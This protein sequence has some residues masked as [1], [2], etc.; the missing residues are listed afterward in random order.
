MFNLKRI[1]DLRVSLLPALLVAFLAG[2][3]GSG[4]DPILGT[5][6]AAAIPTVTATTPVASSPVVTDVALNS[7]V[8]AAFSKD[9]APGSLT[10]TSFML[11]CPAGT[12]VRAAISYNAAT[13]V[14]T[15]TP[16]ASL[17][18]ATLCVATITTAVQD[19]LGLALA[20]NVV[21]SFLTAPAPDLT[22]PTVVMT[23][24]AAGAAGVL[25]NTPVT[26]V[27]S[28]DMRETS[29]NAGSFTL[30]NNSLGTVVPG[31]V[32]YSATGR[33]AVFTPAV[34]G[35]LAP[36]SSFTATIT[37][38]AADLAGNTL[39]TNF[40]WT[41]TTAALPDT[42]RP[43]IVLTV[44][45]AGATAVANNTAITAT[46]SED[47]NPASLSATSFTLVNTTLGT[48]VAGTVSYAA[49]GRTVVFTPSTP[50]NLAAN[51]AYTATITTAAT[52]LAGNALASNFVWS[53]TTAATPDTTR[54][55]VITAVPAPN[56]TAV[57]T[58]TAISVSFSE[59]MLANSLSGSSFTVVNTSS[60]A[61]V[62][63]TVS[64]SATAR[65]AVFTPT[66]PSTLAANTRY[67]ATI[68]NAAA[69]LAGNT[70]AANF[71]WSFTTAALADTTRP[72]VIATVPA[73]NATGVA[74]N[75]A[76]SASFSEDM[77]P[78]TLART[79]FTVVDTTLG[80]P[81]LGTVSYASTG[82]SAIFTPS[83]PATL[84]ANTSYRA[85]ITTDATDLA[86]NALAA[87]FVWTFTTAAAA[88]T[89]APSV[90]A[91]V[92]AHNATAVA[93]NTAVSATFDEAMNPA[94]L[95]STSFTLVN[96]TL[97]TPVA[98]TVSY[99][100]TGRTAVFTPSTPATLPANT[101]FTATITTA[102]TDLAGNAL[103]ASFVWSFTTAA[104]A[105]TTRPTVVTT[106][107]PNN[108]SNV[109]TNTQVSASF[110]ED[111]NP[112]SI[113]STSFRLVNSGTGTAV[114]G[115]VSYSVGARSATFTPANGA[116]LASNSSYTAR[117]TTVVTD[118]AGN[119]LGGNTAI[120][121]NAGDHVW[122]FSTAAAGDTQP[123]VI[124][125]V[126]PPDGS[127]GVCLGTAVSVTFS[128]PMDPSTVNGNTVVVTDN[129]AV[130]AGTVSYNAQ[131]QVA[132]FVPT[133]AAGFAASRLFVVT[134]MSGNSGVK[135]LAGNALAA[136]RSW[137]FATGTQPCLTAINLRTAAAFG[138]F[139]GT[140]GVTNQ[141]IN[142][143]VGG[144]LG[145]T[146]VC[147]AITG[148]HDASN[149]YTETP[150]NV[151]AVNGSIQ[152]APP[153]PG[154]TSSLAIATQAR[155]DAQT[156]YNELAALPPGSDPGAGQ[157]GG[158]VLPGGVYT[159]AGGTFQIT[160]GDLTLDGQGNPN[161]VWVFQS[162]AAL[163]VGQPALPRRVVLI[164]GAR[165]GNV[166]W[167]VGS[168][169]RIADGSEMAGT[170]I[171]NAGVTI[172]TADQTAQT[173][174][175]GR[176]ISLIASVT[177][178]NTTVVAP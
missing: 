142:T 82:R 99:S 10:G 129:G 72:T 177:M 128:E 101:L 159:A 47:M 21:W 126:G 9:M 143:V 110:S 6:G 44:P 139:G 71:V 117:I 19:T 78:G 114:A 26:A 8:S 147:T 93:S 174:L 58:N 63:G 163:T 158:L 87:N 51:S 67:T 36:S 90:I 69:D 166:F 103:A 156:A 135:D 50:S 98:G 131:T 169:A 164:N 170:I 76:I 121:P 52:D 171:A 75:T 55:T 160:T 97:G 12:P 102:A 48:P 70:L 40:V 152:C 162:G 92:P 149:V 81:V 127:T 120:A 165:A 175:I 119:A 178:V 105:D 65:T 53:F 151:G 7:V 106:V 86:G 62:A 94:S 176:A 30:V 73:A 173:T 23:V 161:A 31:T 57:P 22:A 16:E 27:F 155:A 80:T 134:V 141:G 59:D 125:A 14:A 41:F 17:P 116:L 89:T 29:I 54:P 148:F 24:P 124:T 46:F 100:A 91:T 61:A 136:D 133:A 34:P 172:S 56:A 132:S 37:T 25:N 39:A 4:L 35:M 60:G 109:A 3:G 118:L 104:L 145:S 150:L 32:S 66:S 130:V 43:T 28:E 85:T 95:S 115:S 77:D 20:S 111:M 96:S 5:P 108:A 13:R 107:P 123:P 68:T 146:A 112:T 84:A 74:L 144:N 64:Y 38:G 140:A 15:L 157:L 113:T 168:A 153:A 167:Q 42:T 138:T 79:S 122:T 88:D 2:C 1:F 45:A 33:T 18:P 83:N 137:S 154:T 11:N 49:T